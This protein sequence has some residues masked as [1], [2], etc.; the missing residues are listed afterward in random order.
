MILK[1]INLAGLDR[2]VRPRHVF[3][4]KIV[5]KRKALDD[6]TLD[7]TS[8]GAFVTPPARPLLDRLVGWLLGMAALA[9]GVMAIG[10]VIWFTVLLLPF[11]LLAGVIGYL[12]LRWYLLRGRG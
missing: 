10:L 2:V 9:V 3:L 4:M 11:L 7:M 6:R 1:R 8:D 5:I 12:G